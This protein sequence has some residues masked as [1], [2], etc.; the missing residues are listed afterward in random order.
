MIL[1]TESEA[2]DS[3]GNTL[4]I[5]KT[6]PSFVAFP[7][8]ETITLIAKESVSVLINEGVKNTS[9]LVMVHHFTY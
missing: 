5:S 9:L 7:I 3:A 6:H 1:M 4:V 2:F 8:L